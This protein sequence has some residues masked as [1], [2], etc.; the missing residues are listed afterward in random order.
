MSL[1]LDPYLSLKIAAGCIAVLVFCF[2]LPA[3]WGG[4]LQRFKPNWI[5][6]PKRTNCKNVDQA[7]RSLINASIE[8]QDPNG[9]DLLNQW[10]SGYNTRH[11]EQK[12]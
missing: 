2:R 10:M 12:S 1:D 7:W 9:V 3:S 4:I 11:L 5:S 6:L 8:V